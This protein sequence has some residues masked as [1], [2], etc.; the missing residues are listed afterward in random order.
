MDLS[1]IKNG[2]F[3]FVGGIVDGQKHYLESAGEVQTINGDNYIK[4]VFP[5]LGKGRLEGCDQLVVFYRLE[6]LAALEAFQRLKY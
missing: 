1:N 6:G 4:T 2:T 3:R 5:V